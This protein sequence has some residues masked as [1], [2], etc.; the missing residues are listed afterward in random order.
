MNELAFIVDSFARLEDLK[1]KDAIFLDDVQK[2][3]RP[4]IQAFVTG[5]TLSVQDGKLVIGN[6]LYKQWLRKIRTKGFDDEI[7]F[8]Q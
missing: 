8:K 2:E 1:K 3:F 4:D 5:A 6:N 7:D